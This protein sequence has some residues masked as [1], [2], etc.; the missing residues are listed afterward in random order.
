MDP[1][2]YERGDPRAQN[3]L[4]L[5]NTLPQ[6]CGEA[7]QTAYALAQ[8]LDPRGV[9]EH[10]VHAG[11]PRL[12]RFVQQQVPGAVEE[13]CALA[14]IALERGEA[15]AARRAFRTA[16]TLDPLGGPLEVRP[17]ETRGR[18]CRGGS[19][20]S[21]ARYVRAD[22]RQAHPPGA[23]FPFLGFRCTRTL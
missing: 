23:R 6:S 19:W 13:L 1:A 18:V 22:Q 7:A 4:Q 14:E 17:D 3:L 11:T 5:G 12:L 20:N 8:R 15:E 2:R 9:L 21:L 16:R 10:L